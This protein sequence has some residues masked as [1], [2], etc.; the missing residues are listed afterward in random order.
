MN[1]EVKMRKIIIA[2]NWKMNKTFSEAQ[3]FLAEISDYID[4]ISCSNTQTIVCPPALFLELATDF[5]AESKLYVG[6][7]NVNHHK[8]GAHT[9]EISA[10]M[11]SSIESDYCIV[12][13]S[14]RRK[15]Y[16]ETD[17]MVNQKLSLL[18][19]N[20]IIPIVCVGE[21]LEERENGITKEVI[22]NQLEGAFHNI[23]L[24]NP[25]V[26]A[27]EPVWAIGTG[28]TATPQQAQEIHS[29]IR[30]WLIEQYGQA[31]ADEVAILYGGSV[32][33][34]NLKELLQQ[35]DIDGGLIGGASLDLEQFKQLIDIAVGME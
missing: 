24:D 4:E 16:H 20:D 21:T 19:Q 18:L 35:P 11:L 8:S 15:L 34:A 6:A 31:K 13:H 28:K 1:N 17:E 2:G 26:L 9:G 7:Q 23:E 33:P 5:A 10:A 27:Y 29:L 25:V 12:G 14:E 22:V 30:T 32:N 3:D